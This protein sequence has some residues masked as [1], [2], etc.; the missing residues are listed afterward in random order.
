MIV[1]GV[2]CRK[3]ATVEAVLDALKAAAEGS[4][5]KLEDIALLA[6]VEDKAE[7]LGIIGAAHQ[8]GVSVRFYDLVS[9]RAEDRRVVTR[10][11]VT[12]ARYGIGSIAEAA[13]LAAVGQYGQLLTARFM[14]DQAA[15]ALA[16]KE[17]E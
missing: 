8:L 14:N 15:C 3:G 4:R 5:T 10:S 11:P 1:A 6:S 2:G 13:A 12:L 9:L 17:D 16:W 7:E